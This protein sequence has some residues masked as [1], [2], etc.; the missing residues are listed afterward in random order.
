MLGRI[1]L[2]QLRS[3]TESIVQS[4]R[5]QTRTVDCICDEKIIHIQNHKNQNIVPDDKH[6]QLKNTLELLIFIENNQKEILERK[7]SISVLSDIKLFES[8]YWRRVCNLLK[9]YGD[10]QELVNEYG[11][12]ESLLNEKLLESKFVAKN[13]TY[14]F[15]K[16]NCELILG[17][18]EQIMVHPNIPT[19]FCSSILSNL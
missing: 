9:K 2:K 5:G 14:I 16:G 10:C 8:N 17:G 1:E 18:N 13:P 6:K 12:D 15:M 3:V 4:Y 7:L 19:A 11:Y